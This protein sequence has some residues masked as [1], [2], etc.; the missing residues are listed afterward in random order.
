MWQRNLRGWFSLGGRDD[1]V[2]RQKAL[3]CNPLKSGDC[4]VQDV[5]AKMATQPADRVDM[6][7]NCKLGPVNEER[8]K[9]CEQLRNGCSKS[10]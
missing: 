6:I 3:R 4:K 2:K 5:S 7:L 8:H 1:H 9:R 10:R